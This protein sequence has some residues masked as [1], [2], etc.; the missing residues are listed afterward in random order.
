[1][2]FSATRLRPI[3]FIV[4]SI[5]LAPRVAGAQA[6]GY[7]VADLEA[8]IS[9]GV[10]E[11]RILDQANRGCLDFKVG[12]QSDAR[13]KKAG[14]SAILVSAL[15]SSC[16]TGP[17]TRV[18][19]D[20]APRPRTIVK[21][22]T[23]VVQAPVQHDTIVRQVPV[24]TDAVV[25][26]A[27]YFLHDFRTDTDAYITSDSLCVDRL[28]DA[29]YY[30]TSLTS[31]KLCD[32]LWKVWLPA[33]V[34]VEGKFVAAGG[35]S[36]SYAFGLEFGMDSTTQAKY[37][38]QMNQ[39]GEFA[40]FHNNGTSWETLLPYKKPS[41]IRQGVNVENTLTVDIH[42]RS[43]VFY[44]NGTAVGQYVA[45]APVQGW[46]GVGIFGV[47][48]GATLRVNSARADQIQ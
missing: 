1:M 41:A 45:E 2:K 25:P 43:M 21:H 31:R 6:R 12:A 24:R 13:L 26:L 8:L 7:S 30:I 18:T 16:R 14:A 46:A 28:Q 19:P 48:A 44:I 33:S 32:G 36:E 17:A 37:T 20:V 3:V 47:K 27:N 39:F 5:L 42:G 34:R 10:P 9:G 23:V 22:D 29:A 35:T 11:E 4:A 40:V 38:L 15:H